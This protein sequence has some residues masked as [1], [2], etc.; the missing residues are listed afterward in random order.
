MVRQFFDILWVLG[1]VCLVFWVF[2]SKFKMGSTVSL[3]DYPYFQK[4]I[5]T[6]SVSEFPSSMMS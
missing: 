1:W 3:V 4:Q 2:F 5:N 6:K